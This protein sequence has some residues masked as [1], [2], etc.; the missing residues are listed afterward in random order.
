[1]MRRLVLLALVTLIICTQFAKAFAAGSSE[2]SASP[3]LIVDGLLLR[4]WDP[5]ESY[6]GGSQFD[7][8][9]EEPVRFWRAGASL[10]EVFADFGQQTGVDLGFWP[11]R[12]DE[13]RLP[14]TLFLNPQSPPSLRE[15][16][17]QLMWVTG[18][19]F[20]WSE[21]AD[22]RAY[23]LLSTS[24]GRGAAEKL[25]AQ[26]R[27]QRQQFRSE[28]QAG[29]ESLRQTASSR[30]E[31]SRS[32]LALSQG[33]A[34]ARYQGND[35]ALLLDLLDPSR[36]TALV[37]LTS[38]P[39]E[40]LDQLLGDPA[41]FRRKWSAWSPDEQATIRGAF[42]G[43]TDWPA[44]VTIRISLDRRRGAQGFA[45]TA[46]VPGQQRRRPLARVTGLL[47][48]GDL[49]GRE[50]IALLRLMGEV[51]TPEQ[52]AAMRSRQREA[53]EDERA[54]RQEQFAER[55][56]QALGSA[57]NLSQATTALLASLYLPDTDGGAG[58]WELQEAVAKAT[59]LHVVSDCFWP[60]RF[61]GPGMRRRAEAQAGSTLE[62]LSAA[63][64]PGAGWSVAASGGGA[65]G[66]AGARWRPGAGGPGLSRGGGGPARGML[67]DLSMQWG[68]AGS[69]LRFRT[70]S[71]DMWRGALLPFDVLA[72]LDAWLEPAVNAHAPASPRRG[73]TPLRDDVAKLCWL[74]VRLDDLQARLGGAI[75]YEDPND[76]Q[77]ARR[78]ELRRAT[79]GL[80]AFRLPLLRLLATL[81]PEQW[82]RARSD[83][84]RWGYD[85]TPDQQASDALRTLTANVSSERVRDIVIKIGQ[86]D[87]RTITQRDGTER[88]IPPVPA[89]AVSLDGELIGQVPIAGGF[90]GR[91]GGPRGFGGRGGAGAPPG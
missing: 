32:A 21:T 48:R 67:G 64:T 38:L 14:V 33:E 78:Q 72:Q 57:R 17:A 23:Y 77:A 70:R 85:L 25:V 9:I 63:C 47:Q 12:T 52:E 26:D 2:A 65:P 58:F 3:A 37:L 28:W 53:R 34:I 56:E 8:R 6:Q 86:T 90:Q 27:T 61:G 79:L 40:D 11:P 88:T 75:P 18:G 51:R 30:L 13:P 84:L 81:T 31:E 44:E 45:L 15:A 89:I 19:V 43:D 54:V 1:M 50:Q 80:I 59:G 16:M 10:Q 71:P 73:D 20:A 83:G 66:P 68:D 46:T 35:D 69:F 76:E 5:G 42:G 36:R 60:P 22:G 24:V 7:P 49:R 39:A 41:G 87:A 29:Q 91:G 74:A 62:A 4:L 82:A 55:R